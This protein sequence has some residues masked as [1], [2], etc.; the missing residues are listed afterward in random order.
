MFESGT[1]PVVNLEGSRA[2]HANLAST[3]NPQMGVSQN[4]GYLFGG[5]IIRIIVYWGLYWG[6]PILG[7]YQI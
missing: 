5:P 4:Y 3:A 6:P 7:S 2:K 1:E